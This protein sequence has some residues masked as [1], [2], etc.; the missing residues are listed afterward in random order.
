[1]NEVIMKYFVFCSIMLSY[2][3]A[4]LAIKPIAPLSNLESLPIEIQ[5]RIVKNL[6]DTTDFNKTM[7]N[8]ANFA[9]VNWY[10]HN[11]INDPFVIKFLIKKIAKCSFL[12]KNSLNQVIDEIKLG[13]LLRNMPGIQD[14]ATQK[15]LKQR[16]QEMP[17]ENDLMHAIEFQNL[18]RVKELVEK[19]KVNVNAVSYGRLA[20]HTA[21]WVVSHVSSVPIKLKNSIT[22]LK[23]LLEAGA[24]NKINRKNH[25]GYTPIILAAM[26]QNVEA[27]KE[28]L[29]YNPD[30]TI[31]DNFGQTP[32]HWALCCPD[33]T[34]LGAFGPHIVELYESFPKVPYHKVEVVV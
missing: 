2:S 16:R 9:K 31:E 26:Y 20:L 29:K 19:I 23:F 4:A 33:R 32:I 7:V 18:A 5:I 28:I 22:I 3:F 17:L 13:Y 14:E 24:K 15:W 1:M 8:I 10:C 25:R 12:K 27:I 30:L 6:V 11:L 21:I 34:V